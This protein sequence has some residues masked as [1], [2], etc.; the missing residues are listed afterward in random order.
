MKLMVIAAR[1]SFFLA[2]LVSTPSIAKEKVYVSLS[3]DDA[4]PSQ[5]EHAVPALDKFGFKGAFYLVPTN[6]GFE[7]HYD[8]WAQIAERG[9]ELGNHSFTHPCR[10]SLPGRGWVPIDNDLDTLS[11][12]EMETQVIRANKALTKLDGKQARTYTIPCGDVL[13]AGKSYLPAI[14]EHVIAI[15]GRTLPADK[16]VIVAP[17][18]ITAEVLISLVADQPES[19]KVINIIFH[20]VGGDYLSVTK[21]AHMALLAYLDTHREQYVVDTYKAIVEKLRV[22]SPESSE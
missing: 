3:Y 4:L 1:L 18:D 19:V 9:H 8:Q 7:N 16:E 20:G 2:L 12:E 11:V 21:N 10:G 14:R 22:E 17:T 6:P 15:K 13:A 5:L